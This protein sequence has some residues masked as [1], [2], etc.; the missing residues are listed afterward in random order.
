MLC[1]SQGT[2]GLTERLLQ[3][4][5]SHTTSGPF[6][7]N[8]V[9]VAAVTSDIDVRQRDLNARSAVWRNALELPPSDVPIPIPGHTEKKIVAV[10][11]TWPWYWCMMLEQL[12]SGVRGAGVR[13]RNE[14][15]EACTRVRH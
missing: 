11:G 3:L 13:G 9:F 7:F 6:W 15:F 12:P 1:P 10:K 5:R 4:S 8:I 2:A 14:H